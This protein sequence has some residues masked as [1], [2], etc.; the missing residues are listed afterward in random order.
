MAVREENEERTDSWL[1]GTVAVVFA[2]SGRESEEW[3]SLHAINACP[4]SDGGRY[5]SIS[6]LIQLIW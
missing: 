5:F 4:A 2:M 3:Y 6:T 1:R